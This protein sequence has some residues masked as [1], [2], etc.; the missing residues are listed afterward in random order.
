MFISPLY[1]LVENERNTHLLHILDLFS[2]HGRT[3][4]LDICSCPFPN[5]T[6]GLALS[7]LEVEYKE[8]IPSCS[9]TG[10]ER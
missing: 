2:E 4:A 1:S 10:E 5:L 8:L 9:M 7:V 6:N 3:L